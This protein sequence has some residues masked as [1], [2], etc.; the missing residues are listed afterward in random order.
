MLVTLEGN[1]HYEDGYKY[2]RYW[3]TKS[4]FTIEGQGK[5]RMFG[6]LGQIPTIFKS[7]Q[8]EIS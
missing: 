6:D 3:L 2:E 1:G 7:I 8:I 5:Q 4:L